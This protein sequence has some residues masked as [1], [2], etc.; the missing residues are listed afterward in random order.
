MQLL[1]TIINT[2]GYEQ[3]HMGLNMWGLQSGM[4]PDPS[5]TTPL[6]VWPQ[7]YYRI[8]FVLGFRVCK[9]QVM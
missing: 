4:D 1:C 6:A 7:M 3:S 8:S 2:S 9:M 5:S